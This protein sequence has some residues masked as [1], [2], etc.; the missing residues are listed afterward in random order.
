MLL[1]G[2]SVKDVSLSRFFFHFLS[3]KL[4]FFER[5]SGDVKPFLLFLFFVSSSCLVVF[6]K[7]GEL[8]SPSSI[9]Q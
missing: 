9:Q 3:L 8:F 5:N 2:N 1:D 4:L 6:Q 7:G